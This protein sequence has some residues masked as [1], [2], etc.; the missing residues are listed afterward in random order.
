[1][2][3]SEAIKIIKYPHVTEK[4]SMLITKSNT[5]TFIVDGKANKSKIKQAVETLYNVKVD[6]VNVLICK[7]G[8]KAYVRLSKEYSAPELASKIGIM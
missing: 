5:L 7:D 2:N 8:K 3:Q 4:T 6:K 1:M